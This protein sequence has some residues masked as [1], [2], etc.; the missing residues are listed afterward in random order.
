MLF[1]CC[2]LLAACGSPGKEDANDDFSSLAGFDEKSDKFTGSMTVVGSI[3]YGQTK[4]PY[5]HKAG[6]WSALKL[7]ANKGDKVVIDVTSNNG[8]PV[9]WLL[10]K[11]SE[12]LAYN[13]D[14]GGS[15]NS[16]LE[17][18]FK[19][20]ANT[21]FYI[22]TRDYYKGAMKFSVKAEGKAAAPSCQKDS[23]CAPATSRDQMAQ[24]N[25]N[26]CVLVDAKDIQC[27][28]FRVEPRQCP[29]DYACEGD[30]LAYDGP[31][32]CN[33]RCGGIRGLSCDGTD[34]CADDPADECDPNNGGADCMG[35]CRKEICN[36]HTAKC[37]AGF[38]WSQFDCNCIATDCRGQGCVDGSYCSYCWGSFQCIPDGALC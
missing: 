4:G 17:Y 12:I 1:A 5:Q 24:C 8:D 30:A 27:G 2:A 37:A 22:V 33:K 13:D 10:D 28:G 36:G 29:A 9:A 7:T 26:K 20:G 6:K 19:S 32:Q 25:D 3:A 21:T 35:V 11:S 23:D 38:V 18:T 14:F 15:T 16:H 31:G 34:I